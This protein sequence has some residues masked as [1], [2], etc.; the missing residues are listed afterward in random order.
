MRQRGTHNV[1]YDFIGTDGADPEAGLIMD[2]SGN[3]YGTTSAGSA[4]GYGEVF[5]LAANGNLTVLYSF[6]G[7]AD[8]GTPLSPLM[9]DA[10]GNLYGTTYAGGEDGGDCYYGCG[11]VFALAP[12][13]TET[14]LY[15]FTR[16]KDGG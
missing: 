11:V 3:F 12:D 5:E 16:G 14:V 7:G 13:Q 10:A 4:Y 15:S 8:G 6:T 9:M 2:K 1:L